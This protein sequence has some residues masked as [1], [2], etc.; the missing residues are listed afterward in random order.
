MLNFTIFIISFLWL[1]VSC[2]NISTGVLS[3]YVENKGK[4]IE[5]TIITIYSIDNVSLKEKKISQEITGKDGKIKVDINYKNIH[6]IKVIAKNESIEKIFLPEIKFVTEPKWWQNH[7]LNL[8]FNL[9]E[10]SEK[11]I[12]LYKK[13]TKKIDEVVSNDSFLDFPNDEMQETTNITQV[14]S[15]LAPEIKVEIKKM[16][17]DFFDKKLVLKSN[18][19]D[20]NSHLPDSL[21]TI[22]ENK[23]GFFENIISLEIFSDGKPLDGVEVFTGRNASQNI[24]YIGTSNNKGVI[25]FSMP[26]LQRI[27]VVILKKTSFITVLKPLTPGSGKQNLHIDLQKGKSTDFILQNYVYGIG[28]GLDKTELK[29]N[30]LKADISSLVG[31][32]TTNKSIDDN[33]IF[34]LIQKNSIPTEINSKMLKKCLESFTMVNQIPTLY[35]SSQIPYKPSV[36]LIEPFLSS[37]LLTNQLWRRTRR[38]F[39][40]RYMNETFF[41]GLIPDD[42]TKMANSIGI[43]SI[44]LAKNGWKNTSFSSD[45]DILLQIQNIDNENGNGFELEGK[46]YDK[47]GRIIFERKLPIKENDAEQVSAKIYLSLISSLPIEGDVV[48]KNSSSEVTIN[49]G[50]NYAVSEGDLFIALIQKYPFSPPEKSVGILKIKSVGE[51][52]STADIILGQ[53][54]L[55]NIDVIHVIRYPEKI[56]QQEF[57]KQIASSL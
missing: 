31:F 3:I 53:D 50:K 52:D 24:S 43:S 35:V 21:R 14:E 45:L 41:R 38:E 5:N 51:K 30:S 29:I 22:T 26:R 48:K 19:I 4:P 47:F 34:S 57:K 2:D 44:E 37:T 17:A 46:V 55:N 10:L 16:Q 49:L 12:S 11:K 9:N 8:N 25:E 13:E 28:R 56:I 36:G 18:T 6:R 32:V 20:N 42:V 1:F 39:F 23:N 40:S 33:I 27:D 15:N 54:K 7:D